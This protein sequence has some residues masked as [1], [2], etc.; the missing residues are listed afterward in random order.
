ML[1]LSASLSA[2]VVESGIDDCETL[3]SSPANSSVK[4]S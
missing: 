3:Y 1:H 4:M 2:M